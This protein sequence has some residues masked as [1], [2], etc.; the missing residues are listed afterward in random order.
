MAEAAVVSKITGNLTSI[1]V[2][3]LFQEVSLLTGFR[4]EFEFLC[5]E[6]ISIK[7]LFNDAGDK[8]N[9]TLV[10]S[11]LNRLEEFLL[12]AVDIVEECG[13]ARN[14]N[15]NPIFRYKMG[16]RINQLK[17]RIKKI[18]RSTKYLISLTSVLHVNERMQ[19]VN[20]YDSHDK[21]ER[22]NAVIQESQTVG[23]EHQIIEINELIGQENGPR[24]IAIVGMGGQGKTLL[25]QHVFNSQKGGE[26]FD[27]MVWLPV[28]KKFSVKQLQFEIFKQLSYY[29]T[30]IEEMEKKSVK[31]MKKL[32]KNRKFFTD[33]YDQEEVQREVE[34]K[35]QQ[36][37]IEKIHKHLKGKRSLFA[38]DDVWDQH[39]L[40]N[41]GRWG[42][43][44]AGGHGKHPNGSRHWQSAAGRR[45]GPHG[46]D[47]NSGRRH[48][49]DGNGI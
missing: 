29:Q 18:H 46:S 14:F 19:I 37:L 43:A 26:G 7:A 8:I 35:V 23:M 45:H 40:R 38:I 21:R 24:V 41:I 4:E 9:S 11:W 20:A 33:L 13:A 36:E 42:R 49:P 27:H 48:E 28:S 6:I 10:S 39:V 15:W 44:R 1:L 32:S 16:R 5:E 22:S 3:K 17:K 47:S 30:E 25:L 34:R 31:E 2:E 12:D